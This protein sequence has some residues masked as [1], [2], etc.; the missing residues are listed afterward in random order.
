MTTESPT[1]AAAPVSPESD[2]QLFQDATNMGVLARQAI[3]NQ[4]ETMAVDPK[5]CANVALLVERF[6]QMPN[7]APA[8]NAAEVVEQAMEEGRREMMAEFALEKADL[9]QRINELEASCENLNT[10][11]VAAVA[12]HDASQPALV[13]DAEG[14]PVEGTP[15]EETPTLPFS[16]DNAGN[17][18]GNSFSGPGQHNS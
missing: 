14:A 8:T 15:V 3:A 13:A 2:V 9:L 11:L 5:I 6:K 7:E 10:R 16:T 1:E 4:F 18:E 17:A 12:K